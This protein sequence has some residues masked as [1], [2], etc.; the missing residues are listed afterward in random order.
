MHCGKFYAKCLYF[1]RDTKHTFQKNLCHN[2]AAVGVLAQRTA[3]F[4][5]RAGPRVGGSGRVACVVKGAQRLTLGARRRVCFEVRVAAITPPCPAQPGRPWDAPGRLPP[6]AQPPPTARPQ[7]RRAAFHVSGATGSSGGACPAP[8]RPHAGRPAVK[9]RCTPGSDLGYTPAKASARRQQRVSVGSAAASGP[10]A[11]SVLHLVLGVSARRGATLG[12]Q[13]ALSLPRRPDARPP[14]QAGF[15]GQTL[16]MSLAGRQRTLH[17]RL[18]VQARGAR[19][20]HPHGR[21]RH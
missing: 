15:A 7:L 9:L 1:C 2:P 14:S 11:A 17:V 6:D 16:P 20:P 19:D 18:Q 10:A 5:G 12:H 4:R 3:G 8:L 21:W 13:Q